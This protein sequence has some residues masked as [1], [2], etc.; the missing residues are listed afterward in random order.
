MSYIV[1]GSDR[2][3]MGANRATRLTDS[4]IHA[5]VVHEELP[6]GNTGETLYVVMVTVNGQ[7]TPVTCTR[8]SRFGGVHNYEEYSLRGYLDTIGTGHNVNYS[9][10]PGDTV[11]VAFLDGVSKQGVILGGIRH[12][13]REQVLEDG[14]PAY[15]SRFNGVEKEITATGSLAYTY[16]GLLPAPQLLLPPTGAQIQ[17]FIED[18]I[19]AGSTFGF[20]EDGNFNIGDGDSQTILMTRDSIL[21]GNLVI[22]SGTTEITIAGGSATQTFEVSTKGTISLDATQDVTISGLSMDMSSNTSVSIEAKTGLTIKSAGS[23]LLDLLSTLIDEL[24]ALILTSP[25][26]PCSPLMAAP[27]W[28][29]VAAVQ[30]KLKL[31]MG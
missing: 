13:A 19:K 14:D 26:G 16:R 22:T 23:E 17:E 30:V 9:Q 6:A 25:V 18:P 20:D 28:A 3:K 8:L 12:G 11:I 31:M 24:G 10:R 21:G 15:K 7:D 5:G 4:S 27:T 1:P 29:K 2:P